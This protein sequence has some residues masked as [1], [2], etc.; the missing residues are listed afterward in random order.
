MAEALHRIQVRQLVPAAEVETDGV[1]ID[2]IAAQVR[3]EVVQLWYQ[4]CL[5]YTSRCV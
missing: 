3:P 1:D 2:A 5:L 4:I